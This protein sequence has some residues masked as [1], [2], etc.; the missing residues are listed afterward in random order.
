MAVKVIVRG[1]SSG[2][3][4]FLVKSVRYERCCYDD[5]ILELLDS[6]NNLLYTVPLSSLVLIQHIQ[7][8]EDLKLQEFVDDDYITQICF[9][10]NTSDATIEC[11]RVNA[12]KAMKD[13]MIEAIQFLGID[14]KT[15]QEQWFNEFTI[16]LNRIKFINHNFLINVKE[17]EDEEVVQE[18]Q[19]NPTTV[20]V[21]PVVEPTPI[22]NTTEQPV[23]KHRTK[24]SKK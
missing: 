10:N 12:D 22:V 13:T 5:Q 2:D 23:K 6:E 1:D 17:E 9:D 4:E 3:Y 19:P 14:K 24:F 11:T 7:D 8:S 20:P 16:P 21:A 18:E 15:K